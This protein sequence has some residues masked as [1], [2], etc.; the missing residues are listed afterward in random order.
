MKVLIKNG[1]EVLYVLSHKNDDDYLMMQCNLM[2]SFY[3]SET[4]DPINEKVQQLDDC[5]ETKWNPKKF[6]KLYNELNNNYSDS[7][8]A[9]II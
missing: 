2:E 7:T 6:V 9:E 4:G 8:Y 1:S 3:D 5:I